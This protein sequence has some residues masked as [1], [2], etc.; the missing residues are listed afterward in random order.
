VRSGAR[1][2]TSRFDTSGF[3][4][5]EGVLDASAIAEMT[6]AITA[7]LRDR[8][9]ERRGPYAMRHLLRDVPTI[10]E[11][12][13]RG[14]LLKLAHTLAGTDVQPVCGIYFDKT[15][16]ANWKV[17]WHQD[18]TM[19]VSVRDDASRVTAE[20][21][22]WSPWSVKDDVLHVQPPAEV[23]AGVVTLR[24]ALDDC[25]A[26][27]GPLR[28]VPGSHRQGR[29]D[30]GAI[31]STI[32]STGGVSCTMRAGGVLAMH[33]LLL[34]ASRPARRPIRRRVVHLQYASDNAL[35]SGVSWCVC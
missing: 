24:V 2:L 28:V 13:S 33:P 11:T 18:V 8:S 34:H 14:T 17:G 7:A 15:P 5:I 19:A 12:A 20:S 1:D 35:P 16:D 10:R 9:S 29:L 30:A 31:A 22:G 32:A 3:A 6:E 25:D 4:I 26:A 21:V 27:N 23:L